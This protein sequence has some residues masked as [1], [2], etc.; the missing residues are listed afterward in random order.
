VL[1]LG[2]EVGLEHGLGG[3]GHGAIS[4]LARIGGRAK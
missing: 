1:A 4:S 2:L 3:G